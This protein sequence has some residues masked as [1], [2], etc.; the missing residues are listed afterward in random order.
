VA[1]AVAGV[2]LGGLAGFG[3]SAATG[4]D[5]RDG[6]MGQFGPGGPG[7]FHNGPGG[8]PGGGQLPQPPL[9]AP[10]QVPAPTAAPPTP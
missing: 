10:T 1:V 4:G 9:G 5:E 3:I 7:G 8:V 6:R 2:V